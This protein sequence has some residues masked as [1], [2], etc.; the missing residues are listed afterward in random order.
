MYILEGAMLHHTILLSLMISLSLLNAPVTHAM[1][2][3][4][5]TQNNY[6]N[7][8]LMSAGVVG[9][10]LLYY[11]AKQVNKPQASEQHYEQAKSM[12]D[13]LRIE[14]GAKIAAFER[15]YTITSNDVTSKNEQLSSARQQWR[16]YVDEEAVSHLGSFHGNWRDN[17]ATHVKWL[18]ATKIDLSRMRRQ[19]SQENKNHLLV[20]QME[21]LLQEVSLFFLQ[22]SFLNDCVEYNQVYFDLLDIEK[23]TS[24]NYTHVIDILAQKKDLKQVIESI[25]RTEPYSYIKFALFLDKDIRMFKRKISQ[26]NDKVK[27]TKLFQRSQRLYEDLSVI[28]NHIHTDICFHRELYTYQIALMDEVEKTRDALVDRINRLYMGE[29]RTQC[30]RLYWNLRIVSFRFYAMSALNN[31]F[32]E[33][34][35]K[36]TLKLELEEKFMQLQKDAWMKFI[37][38]DN[39]IKHQLEVLFD[40][41]T[42]I[43]IAE[44]LRLQAIVERTIAD[45]NIFLQK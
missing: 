35:E 11:L 38:Q 2:W 3:N 19:L 12:F 22:L 31:Y 32:A 4:F 5:W 36:N 9:T 33:L 44:E 17:I 45:A 21:D 42:T 23:K 16:T 41:E 28:E 24:L 7:T 34:E 29:T 27:K 14:Y 20:K 13:A 6:K 39:E 8:W 43:S 26:A 18:S 10:G 15:V 40:V 1:A 30:V 25:S 37:L